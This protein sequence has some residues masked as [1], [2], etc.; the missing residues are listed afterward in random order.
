ME[1]GSAVQVPLASAAGGVCGIVLTLAALQCALELDAPFG[2]PFTAVASDCR[3]LVV[4]VECA[5]YALVGERVPLTFVVT[6]MDAV[7]S[8]ALSVKVSLC[9]TRW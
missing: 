3:W 5:G 7:A 6:A 8:A 9:S 4:Q 2:E 1:R